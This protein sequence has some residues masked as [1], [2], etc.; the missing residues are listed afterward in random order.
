M[1]E[2]CC[3]MSILDS[4]PDKATIIPDEGRRFALVV[5]VNNS[6]KSTYLRSLL[7]AERDAHAIADVLRK[8]ECNF[9][10]LEPPLVGKEAHTWTVKH[11]VTELISKGTKQDFLLFYYSGHAKRMKVGE[12]QE[13]VYFVTYDFEETTVKV[14]SDL[15]LSMSWLWRALSQQAEAGRVLII[16]DCCYAGKMVNAGSNPYQIDVR[17]IVEDYLNDSRSRGR[18]DRLRL[19]LMAT[20][21]DATALEQNGHGFMTRLLLQA[22]RGEEREVLDDEGNVDIAALAEFLVKEM[23]I[24]PPELWMEGTSKSCIL[25]S[26]PNQSTRYLREANKS[27]EDTLM[28]AISKLHEQITDPGFFKRLAEANTN[29]RIQQFDQ[30]IREDASISDLNTEKVTAFF[31]RNRVQLQDDFYRESSDQDQ[32]QNFELL[33][34]THPTYAALLCFGLKPPKWVAGAFTRCTH[35]S[36]QDRHT[37][38]LEDQAYRGDL[39]QQFESSSDFLRKCLRLVRVIGRDERSE[40]PEIPLVALQE[41]LANALVHREYQNQTS[42]VYVDVFQDRIEISSPGIPPEPMT[43]ELLEEEHKSHPRNP[44]IA[45]IFYLYGYVETVGSGIQRMQRAM[46]KAGLSSAKLELSRDKI[47]KV[48]FYRP[49]QA[50]EEQ[51]DVFISYSRT[52]E[53][54]VERLNTDLHAQQINTLMEPE[55]ITP[56]TPDWEEATR[57]AIRAAHAVLLVVSPNVRSSRYVKDELRIAQMYQRPIF[58]IWAAGTQWTDII[59]IGMSNTQYID[60][61]EE[62]YESALR[63][64]VAAVSQARS[65]PRRVTPA[66]ATP[67]LIIEPR[68]P[69]KGLRAFNQM[70]ARD[71][72]GREKLMETLVDVLEESLTSEK[73]VAQHTRLL[74][75]VGPSGSGKSSVVRAGL[76]P[77]LQNGVLPGSEEWVYLGPMTPGAHP[78]EALALTLSESFP[79]RSLKAIYED[80][81]D[82]SARGIHLLATSLLK[83]S[84]SRVALFIDQFEELFT[85]SNSEYERQHFID[86]LVSAMTEPG[87]PVVVILTLRADFY[88]RPMSYPALSMTI[89]K[90]HVLV[91]PMDMQD[92]RAVI[93]K[94]AELPDVQLTFEGDLVGDL[95]FEVQGQ[96]G[97]LPLLQFTLDQLFQRRSGHLLTFQAYQEIGGVNGAL[98]KHAELTYLSLP[99]EEHRML[100][101]ALFLRLID[102]GTTEQDTTRRRAALT[103]LSLPDPIQTKMLLE[104]VNA[105]VA[106]RLLTT[107]TIAG[108]PT[109]EISSEALIRGWTRLA[110][111]L[112]IA[113]NDILLQY[114]ISEDAAEWERRDKSADRLYRGIQLLEAEAWAERNVPSS[115]EVTFLQASAAERERQESVERERRAR[116]LAL[117]RRVAGRQRYVIGMMGVTSVV[118]VVGLILTLVLYRQLQASLTNLQTSLPVSVTNLN[119]HGLGSL[120]EA[121]ATA[122]SGS[123]ITFAKGLRGTITLTSGE[124]DITKNLL[125]IGPGAFNLAISGGDTSGIFHIGKDVTV[126]ISDLTIKNGHA[127]VDGGGIENDGSLLL[128]NSI[129]SG[130]TAARY[131]GGIF[132]LG[133]LIITTSTIT[134]NMATLG[135][136]IYN[137]GL[138]TLTLTKSTVSDNEAAKFGGGIDNDGGTLTLTTSTISSNRAGQDGGGV[139]NINQ[140]GKV[141]IGYSTIYAN[142][143]KVG[144]GIATTEGINGTAGVNMS[145][146]IVAANNA[147]RGPDISGTLILLYP[148]L[149]QN[150]S[151]AIITFGSDS[152][153][154]AA[155]ELAKH[156]IFGKSPNV[157]PLQNNGEPTQTHAL[158][159]GSPAI[160]QIP[161]GAECISS[162]DDTD[163]RGV[164]RPQGAGCDIGAYEYVP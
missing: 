129:V 5:G 137:F 3:A 110:D 51:A 163:Q 77:S 69:Y 102:P 34:E 156:S 85:Q 55:G 67:E 116:E 1:N 71:F 136:G 75:V 57:M 114:A 103:E 149:I 65:L 150:T 21:E 89:Q 86:L 17:K 10:V 4:F 45:R 58:P 98:A 158:L 159:S 82:D 66:P 126:T 2:E 113:R 7:H 81:E 54:F 91:L 84:R 141:S 95:L 62:H 106:A 63:E 135:G 43:L 39:A 27:R 154:P 94:P 14:M 6:T 108:T 125:I 11:A 90:Q 12:N 61:R 162:P 124:L 96:V 104:I 144:G 153:D 42:P 18:E 128:I 31:N 157:G 92:L 164:Y 19:I 130:S 15:H 22:L 145:T 64:I 132:N 117:Q 112:R 120:R 119:D 20:R 97:A 87:G 73:S 30:V 131:G 78:I 88:D 70:D 133:T 122:H 99:T 37:G 50:L 9:T 13:D 76:L 72:F 47:F 160:N 74:A 49:K 16:L 107:N 44:Q 80:L 142:T 29:F 123:A 101:R 118:L 8:P 33:R 38:W 161:F 148:N 68:N 152:K 32:L 100:A 147:G 79:D 26:Y 105:F 121:I 115:D 83:R 127:T 146:S 56:G 25:A 36:G 48:I 28:K 40:E 93:E 23:P 143:A 59:P 24:Q 155:K 139:A 53:A 111:W 60:A 138:S 109:V 46:E 35:W 140:E 52:D 134:S 41:A 151:G